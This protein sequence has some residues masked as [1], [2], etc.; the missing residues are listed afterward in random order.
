MKLKDGFILHK[1]ADQHMMVAT[2]DLSEKFNGLVRGNETAAFILGLLMKDTTE[3][4]I[5]EAVRKEYS[6]PEN[7]VEADVHALLAQLRQE[8]FLDD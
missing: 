3:Q 6:A 1:V 5:V 7:V 2:G 4:A 8:G